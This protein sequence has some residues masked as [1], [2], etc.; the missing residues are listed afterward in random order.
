MDQKGP[1]FPPDLHRWSQRRQLGLA[2][3]PWLGSALG[4]TVG[5]SKPSGRGHLTPLARAARVLKVPR[6]RTHHYCSPATRTGH[7]RPRAGA[8][9]A[10]RHLRQNGRKEKGTRCSPRGGGVRRRQRVRK[11]TL[12]RGGSRRGEVV[13]G[14][15]R[16]KTPSR[17]ITPRQALI[18][19]RG[20]ADGDG[21]DDSTEGE[22]DHASTRVNFGGRPWRNRERMR[23][24]AALGRRRN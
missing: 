8:L 21:D 20:V 23:E 10:T 11:K 1:H 17:R 24:I 16:R 9:T 14:N 15:P 3:T 18:L 2:G 6:T 13:G 12:A 22:K 7:T 4:L 5:P 19:A